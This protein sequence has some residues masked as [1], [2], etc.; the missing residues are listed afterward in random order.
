MVEHIVRDL[1]LI[2]NQLKIVCFYKSGHV[3]VYVYVCTCMCV[4]VY[5]HACGKTCTVYTSYFAQFEI[6]KKY[7][8]CY[9]GLKFSE[10]I[11]E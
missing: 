8:E 10:V 1:Y 6:Y 3:C 9:T 4:C 7:M 5:A 2:D 11:K